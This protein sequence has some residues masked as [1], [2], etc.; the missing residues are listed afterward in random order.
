M[1]LTGDAERV[2]RRIAD[3]LGYRGCA[4]RRY[5]AGSTNASGSLQAAGAVVA[6]VGD[7]VNDAGPGLQAQVSVR[8]HGRR[9]N[10]HAPIG[11]VLLSEN[12]DHLRFV[13]QRAQKNLGHHSSE[14]VVVIRVQF[15][16]AAAGHGAG[17]VDSVAGRDR[18][19]GQF[20]AGRPHSLR[21]QRQETDSGKCLLA[22]IPV[23]V[24]LLVFGIAIAFWWS[25]QRAVR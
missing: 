1:L 20:P 15:C 25:V 7:G 4:G 3:S 21:I 2:A 11:F 12:L 16:R 9:C 14:S 10:W 6:M 8:R 5:T 22:G 13:L 18:H 23:S 24:L 19:V 17:H